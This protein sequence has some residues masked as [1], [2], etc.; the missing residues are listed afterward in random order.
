[1]S[2]RTRK[3]PSTSFP[4]N[5]GLSLLRD[6]LI[7]LIIAILL[8]GSLTSPYYLTMQNFE[9]L[10]RSM[11]VIGTLSLGVT[12]VM[13][14]GRIDLSVAAVMIFSVIVAVSITSW[15]GGVIGERWVVRGNSF[16]GPSGM[17]IILT[18]VTGAVVGAIN[19]IGVAVFKVSSFIMTLV[20]LT[21]LRGGNYIVTNG[22]PIYLQSPTI[23]W[24]GDAK[25]GGVPVSFIVFILVLGLVSW[26]IGF[27]TFGRHVYAI[28]GN[29]KA[30][31][32]SG[33][34]TKRTVVLVFVIS[35]LCSAIAG[36][37]FT[38]RLKSVDAPLAAGYELTAIAIAVIGG[39]AL[40]GGIGSPLRTLL[41]AIAFSAGLNLL[42]IWGVG[43]WYQNLA[44]GL[45]LLI[46]VGS[47]KASRQKIRL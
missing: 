4:F 1:M 34:K 42:A 22:A 16:V 37:L 33:L 26:L 6:P 44:I 36:I 20:M 9:T 32:F 35:G 5:R 13:L 3:A 27:T 41:A 46:V 38:A 21:A 15:F 47:S 18:L 23:G 43:T 30:A 19:G 14:T 29:E 11:A 31:I 17:V 7:L 40:S 39:T 28:G 2:A 8:L 25:Y 12:V 45:A 10:M 24:I